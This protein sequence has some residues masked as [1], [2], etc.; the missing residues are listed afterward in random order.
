[1][2]AANVMLLSEPPDGLS[3]FSGTLISHVKLSRDA[4]LMLARGR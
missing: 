2:L 3:L 4:T 1:M